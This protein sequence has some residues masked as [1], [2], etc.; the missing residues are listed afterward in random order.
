MGKKTMLGLVA[1]VAAAGALMT[2]P[3]Q[4]RVAVSIGVPL[5][6]PVYSYPQPVYTQ[7][8]AYTPY[9]APPQYVY[10]QPGYVVAQ[11][12]IYIGGGY[13]YGWGYPHRYVRGGREF[14]RR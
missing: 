9:V 12:S 3:A 2:S 14:H 13:G 4:A 10:A 1:V 11:P 6:A 5:A 8:Y 7:P